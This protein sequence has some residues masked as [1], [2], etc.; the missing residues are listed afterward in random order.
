MKR[1]LFIFLIFETIYFTAQT[2]REQIEILKFRVDSLNTKLLSERFSNSK[3]KHELDS[4]IFNLESQISSMNSKLKDLNDELN[5]QKQKFNLLQNQFIAKTDSIKVLLENLF[6]THNELDLQKQKFNILQNQFIAKTDSVKI[7][8]ENLFNTQNPE[9]IIEDCWKNIDEV[10]TLILE[11]KN[12]LIYPISSSEFNSFTLAPSENN[13]KIDKNIQSNKL[14]TKC[15]FRN[16]LSKTYRNNHSKD[17]YGNT[18]DQYLNYSVVSLETIDYYFMEIRFYEGGDYLLID[19]E[20]GNE[21]PIGSEPFFS[22][23]KKHFACG[24]MNC[25]VG[26]SGEFQIFDV[27]E[28]GKVK[29]IETKFNFDWQPFQLKWNFKDELL[30]EKGKC[31]CDQKKYGKLIIK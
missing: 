11:N 14:F 10:D 26:N 6:N 16:G 31:G 21:I 3:E 17:A 29:L 15:T 19:K 23:N 30:I 24:F 12:L 9:S 4:V 1:F 7:L 20:N 27:K 5:L 28:N 25:Y 8:L 2:K 13:K 18:T 22:N